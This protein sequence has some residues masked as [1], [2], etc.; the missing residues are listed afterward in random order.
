M[1]NKMPQDD[2]QSAQVQDEPQEQQEVVAEQNQNEEVQ[3][4]AVSE[5]ATAENTE[6]TLQPEAE[7]QEQY[8][9]FDPV[10]QYSTYKPQYDFQPGDDGSIDP[11]QVADAIRNDV[12]QQ[13]RFEQQEVKAWQQIDQKYGDKLSPTRRQMILDRRV[14]N[15]INGRDAHIGK[16]ADE[17][18]REFGD[19]KNQGR[20]EAT[21]SRKVQQAAS[22]ESATANQGDTGQSNILDRISRGDKGA[23]TELFTSWLEQGKI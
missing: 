14:A 19:A 22:L 17:I 16:V 3:T 1:E 11:Y 13:V 15:A 21:T 8:Q 7:V 18:M 4:E 20:A 6:E 12:L 9:E 23:E 5:E 10:S 2:A